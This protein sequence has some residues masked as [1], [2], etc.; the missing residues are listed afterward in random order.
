MQKNKL[1]INEN[2]KLPD[3]LWIILNEKN[4]CKY[5]ESSIHNEKY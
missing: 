5:T 3:I 1:E 2:L 4:N